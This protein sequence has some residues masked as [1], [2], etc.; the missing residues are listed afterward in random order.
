MFEWLKSL[1]T[2]KNAIVS[3][4]EKDKDLLAQNVYYYHQLN[5][6]SKV[7]FEQ[8]IA[9]F[10][11]KTPIYFQ[12]VEKSRLLELLVAASAVIV[13]FGQAFCYKKHLT[14]VSIV[15]GVVNETVDG[16]T[17]GEVHFQNSFKTM[18]LSEQ[19]LLQGFKNTN[20]KKN[21]GIHEFVHILD[22]ADGYVDGVPEL[23]IPHR[24]IAK[25][26]KL[27][28]NEMPKIEKDNS[29]IRAYGATNV[30]E[31]LTVCSEYFFERPKKLQKEH[32]D[33]YTILSSTFQQNLKEKYKSETKK[34]FQQQKQKVGRNSPCP[35]GSG[36]KYKRCCIK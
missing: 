21:V 22:A 33:V 18:Y 27:A 14:S 8:E 15:K 36:K 6:E 3:L 34:Q 9:C 7:N 16:Y 19:A 11:S 10:L 20:D 13:T 17:T 12:E 5:A 2:N 29:S 32:P 35:C 30:Q 25:W 1:W 4:N 28:K 26:K 31:F 23:F 24:L